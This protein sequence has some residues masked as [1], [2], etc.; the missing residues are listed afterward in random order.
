MWTERTPLLTPERPARRVVETVLSLP[1]KQGTCGNF[2][3]SHS[4]ESWWLL[5]SWPLSGGLHME[6]DGPFSIWG[7]RVLGTHGVWV[8]PCPQ[9]SADH[10]RRAWMGLHSRA[11]NWV[12]QNPQAK[13][14]EPHAA[15]GDPWL[16][17]LGMASDME[18]G[19]TRRRPWA[20][21]R[22]KELP[23]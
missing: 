14:E 6:R 12:L 20:P 9:S 22:L 16:F 1:C 18:G 15:L 10:S 19:E 23:R 4:V 7:P 11:E 21:K 17:V 5:E 2:M 3:Q 8:P 13:M